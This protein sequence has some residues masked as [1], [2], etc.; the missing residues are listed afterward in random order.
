MYGTDLQE[1]CMELQLTAENHQIL[2]SV[3]SGIC[4]SQGR[5]ELQKETFKSDALDI[6]REIKQI[7][8]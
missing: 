5:T 7:T 4:F 8:V 6:L 1:K 2:F 3:S